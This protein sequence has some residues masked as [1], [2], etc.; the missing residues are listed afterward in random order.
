MMSR[1]HAAGINDAHART[2]F[3][4]GHLPN[5]S[6]DRVHDVLDHALQLPFAEVVIDRLPRSEVAWKHSPLAS[7][8]VDVEDGVHDVPKLMFSLSF[9]R[10]NDFFDNL[11]LFIS[12]VS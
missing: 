5:K 4:S 8:L 6:M 1:L 11:P 9:L 12:E 7:G 2:F 3:P 10:I